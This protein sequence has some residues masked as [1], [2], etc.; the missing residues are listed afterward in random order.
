M[1]YAHN[2]YLPEKY[3]G[4]R[5]K[6]EFVRN[7]EKNHPMSIIHNDLEKYTFIKNNSSKF[8]TD[9]KVFEYQDYFYKKMK[10]ILE[11]EGFDNGDGELSFYQNKYMAI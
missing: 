5:W 11:K 6:E 3:L 9:R 4:V 8:H 10:P 7:K 1:Y 2:K